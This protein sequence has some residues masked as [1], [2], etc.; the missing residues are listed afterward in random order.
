M[1]DL[2]LIFIS[3]VFGHLLDNHLVIMARDKDNP[4]KKAI[5]FIRFST[6][7]VIRP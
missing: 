4:N 1:K 2:F 5:T 6:T 7:M 3:S